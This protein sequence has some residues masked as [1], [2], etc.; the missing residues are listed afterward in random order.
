MCRNCQEEKKWSR[1]EK[2]PKKKKKK[3]R[4]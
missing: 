4:K 2:R 1:I 3:E